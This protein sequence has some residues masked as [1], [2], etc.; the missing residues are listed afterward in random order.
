MDTRIIQLIARKLSGEA[1]AGER[2]ELDQLLTRDPE[3]VYYAELITQLWDEEKIREISSRDITDTD[4]AYLKHLARHKPTFTPASPKPDPPIR[5]SPADQR[6]SHLDP[7]QSAPD[8]RQ[9][10]PN[11]RQSAPD[12][13]QS[14]SGQQTSPA[15]QPSPS[16]RPS[17]T[18]QLAW[19]LFFVFL[20][21]GMIYS[22][23]HRTRP[24]SLPT[25]GNTEFSVAL[26]SR[27]KLTLP[28]GT[29]VWLNGGSRLHYDSNML[30]KDLR[31][32]T[33]SGEAF[34]DVAKDKDH[35]FVIQ[36][37]KIA[38]RVLGTAFNVKAYPSDRVTETTLLRGS[39]E[40]TVNSKPYQ[41]IV[42]KPKEKFALIDDVPLESMPAKPGQPHSLHNGNKEKLV[43]QDVVP[44]EVYDK[45]YV[46]EVSWVEDNFVF[47]NETLEEL[48]PKMERWFNVQIEINNA[49]IRAL[50]FTGI[51]HKETI[52]QALLAMQ[53]IQPFKFTITDSHVYIN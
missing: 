46:K 18:R 49:R 52:E 23:F 27:R 41:K 21:A 44:V 14:P 19:L 8:P 26:G 13:Q 1:T 37:D 34:F 53:L 5:S 3:A 2:T 35:S 51:F 11:Q 40:L 31:A 38:I 32:V 48:A 28:D 16:P 47:Q 7:R 39:V 17:R 20:T 6:P 43:I 29:Q 24:P 10:S 9:S 42:L 50:H 33:L 4:L 30:K 25:N 36:T 22:I 12:P 15:D 45:E